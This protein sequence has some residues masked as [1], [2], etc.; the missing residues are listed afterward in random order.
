LIVET[1]RTQ[2]EP[3]W[4]VA[5]RQANYRP[6]RRYVEVESLRDDHPKRAWCVGFSEDPAEA[7]MLFEAVV[8]AVRLL[9]TGECDPVDWAEIPEGTWL[10]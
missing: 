7:D 3:G 1:L 6:Q 8:R 4:R 5:L 10:L 9:T 2:D